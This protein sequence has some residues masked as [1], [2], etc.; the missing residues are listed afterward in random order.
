MRRFDNKVALVT[1]G[2]RD[3]GRAC[4]LRLAGEGA[5]VAVTYNAARGGADETVALIERAGGRAVAIRADLTREDEVASAVAATAAAFGDRIDAFVHVTGGLV[6][7]RTLGEMDLGF[8][9]AVLDV[10]LTSLFLTAKAVVPRMAGGGAIVALASQAGR[11][12]GGPGALAYATS[13]GAVMTFT[14]GLAKELGPQIRVNAVCPGMIATTFHDTFTK[15]EV[16]ERV[17]G[18][19]PLKREG[20][21]DEVAAAVAFLASD[22]AAFV[23]GACVDVN[24]GT[25]FS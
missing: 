24:G 6:A 8:W 10:N 25:F 9:R 4:A 2:G 22:D 18:A 12:G 5:A 15:P 20:Q 19:T 13:K 7:R 11:D 21:S 16:R 14:R 1:G 3:I 17:A 23:T